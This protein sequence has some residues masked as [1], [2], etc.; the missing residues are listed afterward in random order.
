[1]FNLRAG[2]VAGAAPSLPPVVATCGSAC[3]QVGTAH[4]QNFHSIAY[5]LQDGK[6]LI[7]I[8][9]QIDNNIGCVEIVD[10]GVIAL[11][12]APAVE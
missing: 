6:H 8:S 5:R 1:V 4:G 2:T 12:T 11:L 3:Q 9:A 7:F 10:P